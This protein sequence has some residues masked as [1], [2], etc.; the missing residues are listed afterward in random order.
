MT[1][2]LKIL[3]QQMTDHTRPVCMSLPSGDLA[4]VDRDEGQGGTEMRTST[5]FACVFATTV[6]ATAI[7]F[8]RSYLGLGG[9]L[10]GLSAARIYLICGGRS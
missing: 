7:L 3:W 8:G 4:R 5:R 10:L 2:E 1:D 6:V 9:W